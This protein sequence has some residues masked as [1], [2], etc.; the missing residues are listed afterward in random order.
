MAGQRGALD[1]LSEVTSDQPGSRGH[2]FRVFLGVFWFELFKNS[3]KLSS[4]FHLDP[5]SDHSASEGWVRGVHCVGPSQF[6]HL[7]RSDR[8]G[9]TV[10]RQEAEQSA[11]SSQAGSSSQPAR[12][13]LA[14][15]VSQLEPSWLEQSASS[16]QLGSSSLSP[17]PS[18]PTAGPNSQTAGPSSQTATCPG[19]E[20]ICH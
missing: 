8:L 5:S 3:N 1:F 6:D 10:A 20:V 13:K 4:R 2:V 14:R 15:A 18:S 17:G 19:V 16:S 12:T 9:S 7:A 11:S